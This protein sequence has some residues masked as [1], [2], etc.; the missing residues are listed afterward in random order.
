MGFVA[1]SL[2]WFHPKL[3]NG[4][5]VGGMWRSVFRIVVLGVVLCGCAQRGLVLPVS[6]EGEQTCVGLGRMQGVTVYS[7]KIF[8][9]GDAETGVVREYSLGELP[10][11]HLEA[12]GRVIRLT[13]GGVN[14]LNHPTGLAM[15]EGMPTFLGNTVT[16]T[17][18]GR[19]Y[20]IDLEHGFLDGTMDHS[21]LNEAVDDLAV[22][23]ARL[24]YVRVGER[25]L[26]ATSDYGPG[27][28]FVRFYDPEKL[29]TCARTSEAGV[30]V[31][32]VPC[33]PWVQN[34]C[35]VEKSGTLIIVQNIIEGRKWRLTVVSDLS[36]GDFRAGNA[37]VRVI[38]VAGR[39]NELEG[40]DVVSD[41][42]GIFVTSS[43]VVNVTF[44][45]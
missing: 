43:G 31:R 34:I 20:R 42:L 29:A 10:S 23:G 13:R 2:R 26:I 12:S 9:Y 22:Q 27:P 14:L 44:A 45:K 39:E 28:N 5:Y 3:V 18:E 37:G 35:W 15:H 32:K 4:V 33:G 21:V 19:I 1:E 38:D 25:W 24:M 11:L 7:G 8:L 17:K 40:Y 41:H 6:P 30:M 16:K 36:V